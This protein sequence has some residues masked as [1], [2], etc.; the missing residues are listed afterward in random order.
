V[1]LADD[2]WIGSFASDRIVRYRPA[3]PA[4][5]PAAQSRRL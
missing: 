5:P 3:P 4:E 1:E 2:L